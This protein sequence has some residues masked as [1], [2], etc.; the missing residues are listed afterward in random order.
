MSQ[1][2]IDKSS[3]V[4]WKKHPITQRIFQMLKELDDS[5]ETIQLSP[6]VVLQPQGQIQY[7]QV[8]GNRELIDRVLSITFEDIEERKIEHGNLEDPY[9]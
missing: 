3:F 5:L 4:N 8:V 7:A 9:E 1:E 2:P 6:S